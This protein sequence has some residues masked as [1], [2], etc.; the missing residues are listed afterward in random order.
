M[1]RFKKPDYGLNLIPVDFAQQVLPGTFEFVLSHL[2][3]NDLDLSTLRARYANDAGGAPAFDPAVLLK[4]VLLAYSRSVVTSR[5]IATACRNNVLFMAVSRDSAPH[6]PDK[7]EAVG[8][9]IGVV[10]C[11][12]HRRND[13]DGIPIVIIVRD[14]FLCDDR[15]AAAD[16]GPRS[17]LCF[18]ARAAYYVPSASRPGNRPISWRW[19]I[20]SGGYS[21]DCV[22]RSGDRDCRRAAASGRHPCRRR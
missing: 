8:G 13:D 1:P 22:R 16:A 5:S 19:Q 15:M 4:I 11:D 12:V 20:E 6:T 10:E 7:R 9:G 14:T 18:P 21:E 17:E 3:E 2:I